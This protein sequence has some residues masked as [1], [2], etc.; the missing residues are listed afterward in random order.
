MK[1]TRRFKRSATRWVTTPSFVTRLHRFRQDCL[2]QGV[3]KLRRRSRGPASKALSGL[4]RSPPR[5][6]IV[7]R[8]VVVR[9]AQIACS[10]WIV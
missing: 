8:C 6:L 3:R 10:D 2:Q 4:R 9:F 5:E 1:S 7:E